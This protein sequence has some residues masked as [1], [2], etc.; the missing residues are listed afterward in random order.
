[1]NTLVDR[2]SL[3]LIELSQGVIRYRDVG[4]G[5]TLVFVHGVFANGT[6]W[7]D[8]VPSLASRFR[9]IVPDLP[10]G[11]HM[12]PLHP[13][14]DRSPEGVTRLLA[15]FLAALDLRD[16]TL[17][18]NDTGGALCQICIAQYPESIA[19]L[20]LTN[21]DAY[22]AFFPFLLRPFQFGA[23]R[24]GTGFGEFLARVL[25]SRIA[26][27]LFVKLVS[28]RRPDTATLDAYFA[29]FLADAAVRRDLI[30]F[31]AAISNRSTLDAAK[32]FPRFHH[33]VLIVWGQSDPFFSARN[34]YRLQHDFP[35]ATLTFV[36][37]SRAFVPEDQPQRLAALIADFLPVP[38][39]V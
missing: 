23:H 22:E 28:L 17:V 35:N 13:H 1:M 34:A 29:P 19:G 39:I 20:V 32:R 11:G 10:L 27:R 8:V 33:P 30:Q 15:D 2:D 16:V 3:H 18:G 26:Q 36:P 25:R 14:A 4:S 7:R 24:F 5:P 31:V 6:L 9:C 12:Y 37:R 21:C 38:G